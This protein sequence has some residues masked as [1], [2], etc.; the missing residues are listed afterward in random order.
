VFA[1]F[2]GHRVN[3]AFVPGMAGP[4]TTHGK[5]A[6]MQQAKTLYGGDRVL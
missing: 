5:P 4:D 6:T 1:D 2:N 3:T